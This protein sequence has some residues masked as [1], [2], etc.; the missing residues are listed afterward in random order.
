MLAE[1]AAPARFS[2]AR[3][4]VLRRAAS[5][6]PRRS[7]PTIRTAAAATP[8]ARG[9]GEDRDG[10]HVG[11]ADRPAPSGPRPAGASRSWRR[12]P[13]ARSAPSAS[14]SASVRLGSGATAS[15][16]STPKEAALPPLGDRLARPAAARRPP[17]RAR[18]PGRCRP[19]PRGARPSSARSAR[20]S[21]ALGPPIPVAWIVSSP[22]AGR[23][24]R[25]AP[26][27][28]GVVAHLRLLEQLLG[29]QQGA[30]GVADEDRVGGDRGGGAEASRHVRRTL[31]GSAGVGSPIGRVP[32]PGFA[33]AV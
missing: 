11:G 20:T 25:V 9:P 2:A 23:P 18:P 14:R 21:A 33:P 13:S 30:A 6:S 10:L 27:P 17:R 28:A 12:S 16:G 31:L 19:G 5:P 1:A 32:P 22:P 15:P 8:S 24:A 4:A 26:E 7:R 29:E 3:R